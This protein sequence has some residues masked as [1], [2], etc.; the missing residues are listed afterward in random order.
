MMVEVNRKNR[1]SPLQ[2]FSTFVPSKR[3]PILPLRQSKMSRNIVQV[4]DI[5]DFLFALFTLLDS[6]CLI[7]SSYLQ[8]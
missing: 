8:T 4:Y 6:L 1:S 2:V 3:C 5:Y 7:R